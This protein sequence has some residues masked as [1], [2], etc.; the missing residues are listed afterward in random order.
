MKQ[1]F[2][3]ELLKFKNVQIL[4]KKS[5]LFKG[6]SFDSRTLEKGNLFVAVKGQNFDGNDFVESAFEKG[7]TV[8]IASKKITPPENCALIY[9]ESPEKCLQAFATSLREK[10][11][12][13]VIGIVGSVGKTTT[14]EFSTNFLSFLDLTYSSKG[15]KN[16]LLGLPQT[17]INANFEAKYLVLEMGISTPSEMDHLA[18]VAKP[19]VVV[20]TS[21]KPVHIEFLNSLENILFEKSKIL[22][23]LKKPSFFIYNKDDK[24]LCQLPK[25]YEIENYSYGFSEDS[26]LKIDIVEDLGLKGVKTKF[27]FKKQFIVLNLPFMNK[28]NIYNFAAS[29]LLALIFSADI[30]IVE[31]VISNLSPLEHRGLIYH[32]NNGAILYDDSYNSNPE[33]LKAL[34]LSTKSWGKEIVGV[35]GEMKELGKESEKYH[36][37]VGELSSTILSAL[38]CVGGGFAEKMYEC[39]KKS[40]KPCLYSQKLEDGIEFLKLH[41]NKDSVIIVKGSRSVS[42]DKLV[43]KIIEEMG[44]KL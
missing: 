12:G 4:G 27:T 22:N 8:A 29:Y 33:A 2:A 14:K 3:E 16:N 34:L 6:V 15:N 10:F 21:I 11:S 41:S 39:F 23:Y 1:F 18:S 9:T 24:F 20:F 44:V 37:E 30:N 19:N 31:K 13:M 17:I 32:L 25:Q 28:S 40:N 7:A 38:F 5:A 26:D 36:C 42:L 35:L 43:K